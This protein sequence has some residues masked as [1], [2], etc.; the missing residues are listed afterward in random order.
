MKEERKAN[1]AK[2]LITVRSYTCT[3]IV[4]TSLL[5]TSHVTGLLNDLGTGIDFAFDALACKQQTLE[6]VADVVPWSL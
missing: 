6:L 3:S 5:M 4:A 1:L 2:S